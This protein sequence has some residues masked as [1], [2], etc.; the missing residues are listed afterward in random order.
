MLTICGSSVEAVHQPLVPARSDL[1]FPP[2]RPSG[3]P[4]ETSGG[5]SEAPRGRPPGGLREGG[6][7]NQG[8]KVNEV[9]TKQ[10][11]DQVTSPGLLRC[12]TGTARRA[13]SI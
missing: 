5:L 12:T 10:K 6:G 7:G 8:I 3:R 9:A 11:R 2:E 13:R 4:P 1:G